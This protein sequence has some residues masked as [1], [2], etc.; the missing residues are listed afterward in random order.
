[1]AADEG[2][3]RDR[4]GVEGERE[5]AEHA[6][7]DLVRGELHGPD[8]RRHRRRCEQ[9]RPQCRGP[10]QEGTAQRRHGPHRG[11]TRPEACAGQARCHD[12]TEGDDGSVLAHDGRD[13]RPGDTHV[14]HEDEHDF[15]REVG[16]VGAQGHDEGGAGVLVAAQEAGAHE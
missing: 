5:E 1:M 10:H 13:R 14:E 16:G 9:R 3:C 6:E 11:G 8:A 12:D 4:E 7:T 2:L 15:E